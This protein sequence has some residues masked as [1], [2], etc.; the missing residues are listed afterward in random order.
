MCNTYEQRFKVCGCVIRQISA[1]YWEL[2]ASAI[3]AWK[4]G[5]TYELSK[6]SFGVFSDEAYH[7]IEG[8]CS[9]TEL[10]SISGF[11]GCANMD[12]L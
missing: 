6:C 11:W 5:E 2:C 3:K 1:H 4:A 10:L 12:A 8:R 9:S 7:E